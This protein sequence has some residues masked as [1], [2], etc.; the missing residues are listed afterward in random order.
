MPHWNTWLWMGQVRK[1]KSLK[2]HYS[3]TVLYPRN[4]VLDLKPCVSLQ[5]QQKTST[6][7]AGRTPWL[8]QREKQHTLLH[9]GGSDNWT[10]SFKTRLHSGTGPKWNSVGFWPSPGSRSARVR[11][12]HCPRCTCAGVSTGRKRGESWQPAAAWKVLRMSRGKALWATGLVAILGRET[13]CSSLF[14]SWSTGEMGRKKPHK[15]P[16]S[17]LMMKQNWTKEIPNLKQCTKAPHTRE[18]QGKGSNN[19]FVRQ[20]CFPL[21]KVRHRC[22]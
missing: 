5:G 2:W 1:R 9:S 6:R 12:L 13:L 21:F 3:Q 18:G 16:C 19:I 20:L 7:K 14:P 11:S 10:L 15:T 4:V 8:R 22:S 17:F